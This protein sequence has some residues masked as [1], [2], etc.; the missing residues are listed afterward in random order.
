MAGPNARPW[1]DED[2][3]ALTTA[4]AAGD[5]LH[6]I[7][8]A[9]GR[10]KSVISDKAARLGL[11]WDR[12]KTENA[13]HTRRVIA[14]ERRAQLELDYLDDAQRL[15]RLNLYAYVYNFAAGDVT[16]HHPYPSDQLKLQQASIASLNASIRIAEHDAGADIERTKSLLGDLAEALGV[17]T[18]PPSDDD[19][20]A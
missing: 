4:H 19:D 8:K 6:A 9:M 10:S 20:P 5:T 15:R 18:S 11:S 17:D 14:A 1:T 13:T 7:A 12:A 3:A 16:A 2:D